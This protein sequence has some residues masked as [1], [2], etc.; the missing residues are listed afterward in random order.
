MAA[1]TTATTCVIKAYDRGHVIDALTSSRSPGPRA[2]QETAARGRARAR[3][4]PAPLQPPRMRPAGRPPTIIG[5]V[6]A[7]TDGGGDVGMRGRP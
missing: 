5:V 6:G 4:G 7:A 2:S 3:G 1:D